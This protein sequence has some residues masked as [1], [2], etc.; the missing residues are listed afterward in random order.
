MNK[1]KL[2]YQGKVRDIY[3]EGD[4]LLLVTT[5]RLT[6]FD[7]P[8]AEIPHKAEVLNQ[9]SVWWFKKTDHIIPNHLID[10]P[11]PCSMR[12]KKCK[13]FPIEVIVRG[14]ISG[15]TNT[16]IWTLYQ[17]GE[18]QFFETTLPEGLHKNVQL[19]EPILTPTTKAH[20][21][22]QPMTVKD[23]QNADYISE[24]EWQ[25]V[26]AKALELF[27]FGQETAKKAG[28]ILVDTK[29]EFG[30]DEQGN[31]LLVDECHT[32]DSSRYWLL[33]T[34]QAKLA[35]GQEPDNFD[36]EMLRLWFRKN[37]NPYE[38]EVLPS[39]PVELVEE[40]SRRYQEIYRR[41]TGVSICRS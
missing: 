36:K 37:S 25:F 6:A 27:Q 23:I 26:R 41:L 29:Y 22:D 34:Y 17:Q 30:K 12:V 35:A 38:D 40:L 18:R 1:E 15:T 11:N 8:I 16:A 39:A 9:L 5:N 7:R 4:S 32:P 33:D 21:H 3:D 24:G 31:I 20:D 2:I 19:P 14:Y 10:M 13:V 28:L